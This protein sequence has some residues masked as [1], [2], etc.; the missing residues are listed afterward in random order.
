MTHPIPQPRRF[1]FFG[2]ITSIDRTAP[3]KSLLL[4]AEQYGEIYRLDLLGASRKRHSRRRLELLWP[5]KGRQL[6]VVNGYNL[7]NEL[8]DDKRFPKLVSGAVK[9][10]SALV[11]DGLFTYVTAPSLNLNTLLDTHP[12]PI[13]ETRTG[14]LPVC[15]SFRHHP[16]GPWL[17]LVTD[18]LLMPVFGTGAIRDMFPAMEDIVSQLVTKW[19]R[20]VPATS[21]EER[22]LRS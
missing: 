22:G 21:V 20:Y 8:C 18:R 11:H 5:F 6:V 7:L 16:N 9:E 15:P 3:T 17:T 19:E 13:P 14:G 4:L 2:N 1:P 10:I 12:G